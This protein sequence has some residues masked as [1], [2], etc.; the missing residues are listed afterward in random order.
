MV[1]ISDKCCVYPNMDLR[2]PIYWIFV[3]A[4]VLMLVND[5]DLF[6]HCGLLTNPRKRRSMEG[7]T[8]FSASEN[9]SPGCRLGLVPVKQKIDQ[10]FLQDPF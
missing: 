10:H 6:Q 4:D 2:R 8:K 1:A 3:V 9:S 7:N 5:T